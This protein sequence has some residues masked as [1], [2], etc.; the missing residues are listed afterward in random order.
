KMVIVDADHPDIEDFIDWKVIEE[1]KVA[2][3]V[4]GSKLSAKHLNLIMAA[5]REAAEGDGDPFDPAQKPRPKRPQRR[6]RPVAPGTD[7]A[8]DARA[9]RGA[10]GDDPGDPRP[11]GLPVRPP[12]LRH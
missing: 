4:A 8:L 9:P 6:G 7:P 5:C 10:R 2:A 3:L 1:Q 11:A 12:G